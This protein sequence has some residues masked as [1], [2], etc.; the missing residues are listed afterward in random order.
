[1]EPKVDMSLPLKRKG[2]NIVGKR[3]NK[4]GFIF[5]T[6]LFLLAC[7]NNSEKILDILVAHE[8]ELLK[9]KI[10]SQ[11]DETSKLFEK[12]K[13]AKMKLLKEYFAQNRDYSSFIRNNET[14]QEILHCRKTLS[15]II[16][17]N[18]FNS[19]IVNLILEYDDEIKIE[20]SKSRIF[21]EY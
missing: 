18:I 12:Y 5:I 9:Y 3:M 4:I 17:I 1:M 14:I 13:K 21:Y 6:V 16:S 2:K 10:L 20:L 7:R 19:R 15:A 11:D 8:N